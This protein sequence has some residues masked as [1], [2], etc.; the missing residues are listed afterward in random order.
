MKASCNYQPRAGETPGP[1]RLR[2]FALPG[3]RAKPLPRRSMM[4]A[5][6]Q[7]ALE[8]PVAHSMLAPAS[9]GPNEFGNGN[10]RLVPVNVGLVKRG[11]DGPR[12]PRVLASASCKPYERLRDSASPPATDLLAQVVACRRVPGRAAPLP[13]SAASGKRPDVRGPSDRRAPMPTR[14]RIGVLDSL[15]HSGKETTLN[16]PPGG[17]Y[18]GAGSAVNAP[19]APAAT[20]TRRASA[21]QCSQ[22]RLAKGAL[23]EH[24]GVSAITE[25]NGTIPNYGDGPH[26]EPDLNRR[27]GLQLS[28]AIPPLRCNKTTGGAS[29][30]EAFRFAFRNNAL[31][32]VAANLNHGGRK[33]A[34]QR[35]DAA[36]LKAPCVLFDAEA[37]ALVPY[38]GGE[39]PLSSAAAANDSLV[40]ERNCGE[41]G[42][43]ESEDA[44]QPHRVDR[45]VLPAALPGTVASG[46]V[47]DIKG[48]LEIPAM[49]GGRHLPGDA[50]GL[51]VLDQPAESHIDG[52][53]W[54]AAA[55][56]VRDAYE[57]E[58]LCCGLAHLREAIRRAGPAFGRELLVRHQAKRCDMDSR[59]FPDPPG[60]SRLLKRGTHQSICQS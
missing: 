6:Y 55:D 42:I 58:G 49:H 24:S 16:P 57:S 31:S 18:G 21:A 37:D 40:Q 52:D 39:P 8:Y 10:E 48:P 59:R 25:P 23:R 11:S 34:A 53:N 32:T 17:R 35:S 20:D 13:K 30:G 3:H 46:T 36:R 47:P 28:T 26:R 22:E 33:N 5:A 38:R 43:R 56:A 12:A 19:P 9:I 2:E 27:P 60:W 54:L 1:P 15:L 29:F 41:T 14:A 45:T 50:S 44:D 51:A 4:V 7:Q